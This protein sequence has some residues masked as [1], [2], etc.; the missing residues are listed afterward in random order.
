MSSILLFLL[1][2]S[3]VSLLGLWI[4]GYLVA[5]HQKEQDKRRA[6]LRLISQPKTLT[7][8]MQ[9][10]AF[11]TAPQQRRKSPMVIMAGLVGADA[12]RMSQ[13]PIPWWIVLPLSLAIA[14]GAQ[15]L[16]SSMMGNA[17]WALFPIA[18]LLSCRH[19][20]IWMEK[21][22]KQRAV[23]QLPD[24]L[25]QIVRGVRVG[26]PVLE[27][28]RS[29]ARETPEPTRT[30][31]LRLVDQVAVGTPLEEAVADMATRSGLPEYNFL[32]TA[33]A[34]QNQTGG[35]LSETL[36]GLAEVVRKRVAI[37]EKGKALSSEA[38]ATA[39][40]L[41]VLPF[42][43]GIIMYIMDPPYMMLLITEPMGHNMLAGAAVSLLLGLL[44]IRS[45]FQKALALS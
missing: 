27:A 20:F 7:A 1:T 22:R 38:K 30:E 36:I 23:L 32:A 15:V 21:R 40:V 26:M 13:Y 25:D 11:V 33:L 17:S 12:T 3:C 4:S 10:S 35:G 2:V 37:I 9:V 8:R 6:R 28:I 39:V 18:W 34:L 31:F 24:I 45:M 14:K 41:T 43:T 5:R 29:S 42:A 44:C 16:G 19:V